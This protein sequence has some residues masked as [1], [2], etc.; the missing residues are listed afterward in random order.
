MIIWTPWHTSSNTKQIRSLWFIQ[1]PRT[2]G[3]STFGQVSN[4]FIIVDCGYNH[5][6][7]FLFHPAQL[8]LMT[9]ICH[10]L[11]IDYWNLEC[12][13]SCLLVISLRD[14][15]INDNLNKCVVLVWMLNKSFPLPTVGQVSI[16]TPITTYV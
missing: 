11:L 1:N 14:I 5:Y 2:L 12:N 15:L 13:I 4:D 3:T 16:V 9:K 7:T 8:C 6:F 10:R